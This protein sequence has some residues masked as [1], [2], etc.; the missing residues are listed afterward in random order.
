[1]CFLRL[2]SLLIFLLIVSNCG[3][4]QELRIESFK[5]LPLD[6]TARE[7]LVNDVNGEPCALLK[8]K[9]GLSN[10][11]FFTN[12]SVEKTEQRPGE[13]WVWVSPGSKHFKAA[14]SDFPIV[15]FQ[16]PEEVQGNNVYSVLLI[17]IFPE[18]IIYRDT[19]F[20]QPFVSF[21]SNPSEAEVYI[22]DIF[23]GK[24]PLKVNIPYGHFNYQIVKRKYY[25]VSGSDS[26]NTELKGLAFDILP[27]PYFRRFFITGSIGTNLA[28]R[29][30]FGL[31]SGILG[32][33]GIYFSSV[34][35]FST[36][37]PEIEYDLE[38]DIA[39]SL[40]DNEGYYYLPSYDGDPKD[41]VSILTLS[42][43][44]TNQIIKNLFIN[45]GIGYSSRNYYV[46][47]E[48]YA[49]ESYSESKPVYGLIINE[50]Y[51]GMNGQLGIIGRFKNGLLL[52]FDG[53]VNFEVKS[54]GIDD[55]KYRNTDLQIS[56]GYCF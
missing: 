34:Y 8:V 37:D 15:E 17:A 47:L 54:F 31:K 13:Y 43:G 16:F 46:G 3:Y 28:F 18:N 5:P 51:N 29:P 4:S 53:T 32:R 23:Y 41:K 24:T 9:T 44:L 52:S 33:T 55:T 27:D 25:S 56:V 45:Y 42:L 10:V 1:M 14:V 19:S 30:L 6:V 20:F 35:S 11:N 12:L 22:D 2:G 50:S 38:N 39:R 7:K 36:A 26:T 48:K 49:Y 21:T 40:I